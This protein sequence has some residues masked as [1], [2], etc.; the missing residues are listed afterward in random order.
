MHM[1]NKRVH[2]VLAAEEHARYR[3]AA[4]AEGVSLSEWLRAAADRHLADSEDDTLSTL[5]DL[6]AFFEAR[7][8]AEH[9]TEP[10]WEEHLAVIAASR[11]PS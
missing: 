1:G 5:D 11:L 4:T 8:R 3:A 10:D 2:L 9:G 6:D 7:D